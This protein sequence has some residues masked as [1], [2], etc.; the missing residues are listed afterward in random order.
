M[1]VASSDNQYGERNMV[2]QEEFVTLLT[3]G[4]D[5][6]MQLEGHCNR[7]NRAQNPVWEFRFRGVLAYLQFNHEPKHRME[8]CLQSGDD[9]DIAMDKN[10]CRVRPIRDPKKDVI[11]AS[12][13][14]DEDHVHKAE[15]AHAIGNVG[16]DRSARSLVPRIRLRGPDVDRGENDIDDRQVSYEE[17]LAAGG[18]D[19]KIPEDR[20][21]MLGPKK[22]WVHEQCAELG[23]PESWKW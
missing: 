3:D 6:C 23:A 22:W 14:E 16:G 20:L 5:G 13:E 4:V 10:E 21:V 8:N 18:Y 7:G 19:K 12:V 2:C 1:V 15:H 9:S 11:A 17:S